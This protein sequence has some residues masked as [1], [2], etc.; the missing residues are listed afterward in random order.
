MGPSSLV[1]LRHEQFERMGRNRPELCL[2]TGIARG[3]SLTPNAE[4][5]ITITEM[6]EPI[7]YVC[8]G[9]LNLSEQITSTEG[10]DPG[11]ER[12]VAAWIRHA[13]RTRTHLRKGDSGERVSNA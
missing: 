6:C 13:S 1:L 4:P 7:L 11:S 9:N 12:T 2:V 5:C 10:F 8:I 3:R